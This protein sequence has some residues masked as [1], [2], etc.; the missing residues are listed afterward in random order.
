[1]RR[2]HEEA[3]NVEAKPRRLSLLNVLEHDE[4][5]G[6]N[7]SYDFSDSWSNKRASFVFSCGTHYSNIHLVIRNKT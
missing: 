5:P 1:M 6:T 2:K 4:T 3:M 7:V